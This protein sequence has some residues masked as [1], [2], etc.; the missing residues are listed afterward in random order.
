MTSYRT[1]LTGILSALYLLQAFINFTG[2]TPVGAPPLFCNNISAVKRA[3]APILPGIK[4][5]VSPDF[6]LVQ[7]IRSI[8]QNIPDF[9]ASWVKTHQDDNKALAD[10]SLDAQLNVMAD[11]D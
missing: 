3:N 2:I 5:H 6:D 8:K 11:A 4:T 1:E 7:E 9:T 10:L